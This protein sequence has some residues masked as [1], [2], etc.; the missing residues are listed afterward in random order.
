MR[1]YQFLLSKIK[2]QIDWNGEEFVF[3]HTEED[4]YHRS[5]EP[6]EITLKGIYHQNSS[7]VQKTTQDAT[8]TKSK[9]SPMILCLYTD[10][11]AIS[12][13]DVVKINGKDMVVTGIEN[14][15]ELNVALQLSLEV[16]E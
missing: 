16:N 7:Y 12:L 13:Q 14:V 15:Q 5:T 11:N 10:G 6:T 4:K 1:E 9:P 8:V 3:I 2:H